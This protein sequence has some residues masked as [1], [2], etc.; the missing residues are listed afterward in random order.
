MKFAQTSSSAI[1]HGPQSH[2]GALVLMALVSL[3]S[4][5]IAA[6]A[7]DNGRAKEA[8]KQ[9]RLLAEIDLL[10]GD[11]KCASDQQCRVAG[12]GSLSCGGPESYRAWSMA[13]TDT[14]KLAKLLDAYATERQ[15]FNEALGLM[16]TC[17]VKPVPT[18]RCE[19]E[20]TASAKCAL[21]GLSSDLR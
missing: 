10:I 8:Q 15:R 19:R 11:A 20:G 18:A 17:E 13:S 4:C 16:T 2:V 14:K 1:F 6:P 9:V 12:L 21:S 3:A 5:S 7:S